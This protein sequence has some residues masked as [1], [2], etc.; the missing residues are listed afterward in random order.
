M[1]SLR[2]LPKF[3]D[4]LQFS[5]R[6]DEDGN[7]IVECG[8]NARARRIICKHELPFIRPETIRDI[9]EDLKWQVASM[10]YAN[11]QKELAKA[12]RNVQQYWTPIYTWNNEEHAKAMDAMSTLISLFKWIPTDE[13]HPNKEKTC[14]NT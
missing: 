5:T 11:E 7:T 9:R 4:N 1:N 12:L 3:I 8:F 14:T 6:K 2:R 10:L 13:L